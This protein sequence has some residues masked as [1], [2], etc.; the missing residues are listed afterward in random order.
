[1]NAHVK[2]EYDMF[3]KMQKNPFISKEMSRYHRC[4]LYRMQ[5][6]VAYNSAQN[7]IWHMINESKIDRKDLPEEILTI[8][9]KINSQIMTIGPNRTSDSTKYLKWNGKELKILSEFIDKNICLLGSS[10]AGSNA[11]L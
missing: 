9:G 7:I 3:R 1:M 11:G 8:L 5:T 4:L 10:S 6:V 2:Y